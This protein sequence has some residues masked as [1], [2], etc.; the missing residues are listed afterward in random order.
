MSVY[1]RASLLTY[2]LKKVLLAEHV[3]D[4]TVVVVVAVVLVI[5]ED[6]R[7]FIQMADCYA[8]KV[9]WKGKIAGTNSTC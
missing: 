6:I 2:V 9:F 5:D 4:Q 8:C 3:L 1:V 7:F